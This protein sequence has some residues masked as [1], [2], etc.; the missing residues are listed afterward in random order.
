MLA[1]IARRSSVILALLAMMVVLAGI[2]LPSGAV[3]PYEINVI[4]SL[5]GPLAF[6]GREL[7]EALHVTES[8]VNR[9]GGIAGRPIKFVIYDDQTN[10]QT[11]VQ[12]MSSIVAKK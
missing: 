7:T 3:D 12:L 1:S 2:P 6:V 11:A 4:M 9:S 8:T 5:T 10:P